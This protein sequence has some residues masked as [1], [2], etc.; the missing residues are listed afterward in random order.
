MGKHLSAPLRNISSLTKLSMEYYY[1][2]DY[3]LMY[4]MIYCAFGS[5]L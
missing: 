1:Y 3:L 4:S 5:F 2:C